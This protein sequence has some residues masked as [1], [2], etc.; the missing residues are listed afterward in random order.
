MSRRGYISGDSAQKSRVYDLLQVVIFWLVSW[1]PLPNCPLRRP[2]HC[3][4]ASCSGRLGPRSDPGFFG[5]FG[6]ALQRT[7]RCICVSNKY[8]LGSRRTHGLRLSSRAVGLDTRPERVLPAAAWFVSPAS[9]EL[10]SLISV[11]GA[12]G[13]SLTR[14]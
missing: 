7:Y 1:P 9:A 2:S 5:L 3:A 14:N 10:C 4:C 12:D 13:L 11:V 6:L 8:D